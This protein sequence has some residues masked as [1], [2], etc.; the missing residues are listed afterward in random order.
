MN[1]NNEDLYELKNNLNKIE[2]FDVTADVGYL[3][4]GKDLNEGFENSALAM[5]EVM[6]DT[7]EISNKIEEK[8][9]IESEDLVSLLYDWLEELLIKSEVEL[10][11]YNS[12]KVKIIKSTTGYKLDANIC[13]EEI[14][15]KK[16][17]ITAEVKAVTFHM[18]DIEVTE[19]HVK[20][21]VILDL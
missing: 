16:H 18:M 7:R 1:K 21:R 4:Y 20:C 5:F 15:L 10:K 19:N 3:A 12:F 6:T 17:K 9:N 11:L 8:I 14:N 2:F 13:G